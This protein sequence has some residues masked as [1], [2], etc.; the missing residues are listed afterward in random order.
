MVDSSFDSRACSACSL[1]PFAVGLAGDLAGALEQLLERAVLLDQAL[2]PLLADA[3]ARRGCCR[4]SRPSGPGRRPPSPAAR[5]SP[6]P[7]RGA[8]ELVA[9]GVVEGDAGLDELHQVLVGGD[10][11]HVVARL[12]RPAGEGAEDVVRLVAGQLQ[13]GDAVGLQDAADPGELARAGP[14]AWG[15]GWPCSPRTSRCGRSCPTS[16]ATPIRS[17]LVLAQELAQ[18]GDEAVDGVGRLPPRVGEVADGVEGAEDVGVAVDQEQ[19]GRVALAVVSVVSGMA[20]T[21]Y[22]ILRPASPGT[23]L[24]L[25]P[26]EQSGR[27]RTE[28]RMDM[29]VNGA[30]F[31]DRA[32]PDR[33]GHRQV[34]DAGAGPG[35]LHHHHHHRRS[36]ARCSAASWP[37]RSASAA[38]RASTSAAWSSPSSARSCC[39]SSGG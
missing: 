17:G 20:G 16:R 10:Q 5:R 7:P 29:E 34:P 31:V 9:A 19:T 13:D 37:P 12:G 15:R 26:L 28:R 36:S 1:E 25:P 30:A 38:S 39:W 21:F 33:R 4:S 3:R 24:A 23:G 14:R 32:R 18:H 11:D 2:G 6:P 22:A 35:R 27:L 8:V